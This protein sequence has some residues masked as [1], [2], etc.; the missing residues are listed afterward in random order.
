MVYSG[1]QIKATPKPVSQYG[2]NFMKFYNNQTKKG[3]N[4][5]AFKTH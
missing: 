3:I 1:T 2:N 5:D 4:Q